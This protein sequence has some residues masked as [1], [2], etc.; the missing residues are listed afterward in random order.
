MPIPNGGCPTDSIYFYGMKVPDCNCLQYLLPAC[1]SNLE[2]T[3]ILLPLAFKQLLSDIGNQLLNDRQVII[4]RM[5]RLRS[6]VWNGWGRSMY[7]GCGRD[8]AE[9]CLFL[10]VM[11]K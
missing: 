5:R 3:I 7:L 9:K 8:G 4:T 1:L 11:L 2:I 6:S 10:D